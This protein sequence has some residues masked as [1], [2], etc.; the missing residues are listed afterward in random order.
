VGPDEVKSD[1]A[2]EEQERKKEAHPGEAVE[3]TERERGNRTFEVHAPKIS[4]GKPE[5]IRPTA[6]FR[7]RGCP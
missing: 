3:Q 5:G 6:L 7:P 4:E 1:Q 2:K